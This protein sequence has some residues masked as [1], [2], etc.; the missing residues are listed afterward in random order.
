LKGREAHESFLQHEQELIIMKLETFFVMVIFAAESAIA[1][2][3]AAAEKAHYVLDEKAIASQPQADQYMQIAHVIPEETATLE[4]YAHAARMKFTNDPNLYSE[5]KHPDHTDAGVI[6][7][8]RDRVFKKLEMHTQPR[9]FDP[10]HDN[11]MQSNTALDEQANEGRMATRII[12][13]ET[14]RYAQERL[15]EIEELIK[16]MRLEVSTDMISRES[17]EAAAMDSNTRAARTV[18]HSPV[19]YRFFLKTGLRIP[20]DGVKLGVVSETEATYGNLSSFFKV[21]LDGRYDSTAGL[22]YVLSRDL[23]VQVERQVT[24]ATVLATRDTMKTKSSLG[25]VQLVCTF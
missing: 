2:N 11:R 22:I 16:A 9:R 4:L 15:P 24:H 19:E 7:G 25:L 12:L 14:L 6:E 13:K 23:R 10:L 17:D 5:M 8:W 1:Q 18:H 3:M 20:V 21:R